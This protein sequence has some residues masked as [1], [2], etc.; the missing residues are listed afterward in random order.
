MICGTSRAAE[1]N[2]PPPPLPYL[3]KSSWRE[4]HAMYKPPEEAY[5]HMARP[6]MGPLLRNSPTIIS[7]KEGYPK[8]KKERAV[9]SFPA[10]PVAE[11]VP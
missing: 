10:N 1:L 5:L 11:K 6:Y 7:K 9:H 4:I 8:A 3:L 2:C